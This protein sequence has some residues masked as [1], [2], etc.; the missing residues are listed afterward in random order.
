MSVQKHILRSGPHHQSYIGFH[1]YQKSV[2]EADK[3]LVRSLSTNLQVSPAVL[4]F[5]ASLILF[6]LHQY[7][8]QTARMYTYIYR[9]LN[10]II[11]T[12]AMVE[13]FPN[14]IS[15][16]QPC[17]RSTHNTTSGTIPLHKLFF[18]SLLL[19][20]KHALAQCVYFIYIE[21]FGFFFRR[22]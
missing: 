7:L 4:S 19:P 13:N 8:I 5:V 18:F 15:F 22:L 20:L 11:I 14:N 6:F 2:L 12:I 10:I 9:I 21:C 3:E 17:R 16:T 1:D